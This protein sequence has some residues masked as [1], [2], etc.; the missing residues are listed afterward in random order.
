MTY[1]EINKAIQTYFCRENNCGEVLFC[2][3]EDSVEQI[4]NSVNL[5]RDD[6]LSLLKKVSCKSWAGFINIEDGIFQG[7]GILFLQSYA[8]YLMRETDDISPQSYNE[9]LADL[10]LIDTGRLQLLYAENIENQSVQDRLWSLLQTDLSKQDF[11]LK[12]PF[13]SKNAGRYVQYPKSQAL[14]NTNDLQLLTGWFLNRKLSPRFG[15]DFTFILKLLKDIRREFDDYL[16]P[17]ARKV[18]DTDRETKQRIYRQIFNYFQKWDGTVYRYKT[19]DDGQLLSSDTCPEV[20]LTLRDKEINFYFLRETHDAEKIQKDII[21]AVKEKCH[22]SLSL[23]TAVFAEAE[24][25]KNEYVLSH[26]VLVGQQAAILVDKIMNNRLY[27][28]LNKIVQPENKLNHGKYN[29][30]L[31]EISESMTSGLL[32]EYIRHYPIRLR[33]G[34][35]TDRKS[36]LAGCGPNLICESPCKVRFRQEIYEMS[37][38]D[39][40]CL[41]NLPPEKYTINIDDYTPMIFYITASQNNCSSEYPQSGWNV[42]FNPVNSDFLLNGIQV[43]KSDKTEGKR[44]FTIIQKSKRL[45]S[46]SITQQRKIQNGKLSGYR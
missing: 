11:V 30:F 20:L 26:R 27:A 4:S 42:L 40:I 21:Y 46:K 23:S 39:S 22:F 35:K 10:L 37:A 2:F 45:I 24:N 41:Q 19:G 5:D 38:G 14:L 18:F 7:Y 28:H 13:P 6:L 44:R 31:F 1:S 33:G 15:Y 36:W 3:D 8:A 43:F 12:I 16:T 29:L 9:R 17:H 34:L 25:Y 32:S